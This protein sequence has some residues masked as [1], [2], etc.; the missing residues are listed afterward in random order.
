MNLKQKLD[1]YLSD[2]LSLKQELEQYITDKSVSLEDRWDLWISA[3]ST[4]KIVEPWIVHFKSLPEH[5]IMYDGEL[6]AERYQTIYTYEI[7]DKLEEGDWNSV[8]QVSIPYD[9]DIDA[10]KEEIL[11]HNLGSFV[12]DW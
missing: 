11:S 9:I 3:P 4:L 10:V 8:E 7:I 2:T 5:F 12:Y 6:H 1:I